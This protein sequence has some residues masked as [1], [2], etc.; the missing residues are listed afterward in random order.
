MNNTTDSRLPLPAFRR[1][2]LHRELASAARRDGHAKDEAEAAAY[3]D[4][5][6]ADIYRIVDDE[7]GAS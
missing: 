3:A 4:A 5:M 2:A 6:I 1:A 7:G